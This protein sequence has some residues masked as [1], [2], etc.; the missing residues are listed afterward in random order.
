M[1]IDR[2][3][4]AFIGRR[5]PAVHDLVPHGVLTSRIDYVALNPQP[6]PPRVMGALVAGKLLE[7][8][9]EADRFG[10]ELTSSADWEDELCPRWPRLPK[11][12]PH[13]G[14]S[15]DPDPG[16]D[17]LLDYHFGVATTLAAAASDAELA[18]IAF[19]RCL[20]ALQ[21]GLDATV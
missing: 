9:W 17:W 10:V 21:E 11:L 20:D 4:L 5:F 7:L 15:P 19:K 1:T 8:G 13:V 18:T 12:P 6:L 14:T 16:P 2:T 3:F